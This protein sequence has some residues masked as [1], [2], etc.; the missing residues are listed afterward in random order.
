MGTLTATRCTHGFVVGEADGALTAALHLPKAAAHPVGGVGGEAVALGR[1]KFL[2]CPHQVQCRLLEGIGGGLIGCR[3]AVAMAPPDV[4][5][6]AQVVAHQPVA[7]P[8][9]A[10]ADGFGGMVGAIGVLLPA[11][12]AARQLEHGRLRERWLMAAGLHP[13]AGAAAVVA[14]TR[15]HGSG[16]TAGS[17]PRDFT[18]A[19]TE[20]AN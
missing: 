19:P 9:G 20:S 8:Q 17:V 6:Q 3:Q 4:R 13:T 16:A 10:A 14:G 7:G 11:L 2:G 12:D 18:D 15:G 1:I 5:H